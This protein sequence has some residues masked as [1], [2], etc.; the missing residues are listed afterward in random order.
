M[1][2]PSVRPKRT[3]A[4]VDAYGLIGIDGTH[5]FRIERVIAGNGQN[6][7]DGWLRHV[8]ALRQAA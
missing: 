8:E 7:L 3:G 5:G 6:Q 1:F 4:C 2:P